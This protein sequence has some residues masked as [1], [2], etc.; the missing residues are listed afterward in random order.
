MTMRIDN[1]E[2]EEEAEIQVEAQLKRKRKPEK[3]SLVQKKGR[4]AKTLKK[5]RQKNQDMKEEAEDPIH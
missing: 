4:R 1:S 3:S 5:N 2:E